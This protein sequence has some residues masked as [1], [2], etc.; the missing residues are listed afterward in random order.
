M[1]Q[2]SYRANLSSTI[3]PMTI[4]KGGRT[5]INPQYDQ[6][7]DKRVD[8][9][10]DNSKGSAGIPQALYMQNV[11]PT[12]DGFQ[13]IRLA[14]KDPITFSGDEVITATTK[15][16]VATVQ[17]GVETTED[18]NIT[19]TGD[20][21]ENWT[22]SSFHQEFANTISNLGDTG[23]HDMTGSG[24]AAGD[25][26]VYSENG[27]SSSVG[28]PVNSYRLAH[29]AIGAHNTSTPPLNWSPT[30]TSFPIFHPSYLIDRK[31]VV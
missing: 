8:S 14:V 27:E 30:Q 23:R 18:V 2:I 20:T 24:Y 10:G 15:I 1:A 19:D 3:F 31:S 7:F 12:P 25:F 13:S 11:L 22:R 5:V 16:R 29:L 21:I 26:L 4:A 28:D 9:P 6:N 17:T